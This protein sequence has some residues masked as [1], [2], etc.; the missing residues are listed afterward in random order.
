MAE[1]LYG[2]KNTNVS[3][4]LTKNI[5]TTYVPVSASIFLEDK[6]LRLPVLSVGSGELKIEER[7]F[8][9]LIGTKK[10]KLKEIV[11][12]SECRNPSYSKSRRAPGVDMGA[13]LGDKFLLEFEIKLTVVPTHA[14]SKVTEMIVRQNTQFNFAE[15]L[16]YKFGRYLSKNPS[17]S[18]L[19]SI[20]TKQE[21]NQDLFILHGIWKTVNHDSRIDQKN[22]LDVVAITDLAYLKILLNSTH[23]KTS[24]GTMIKTRIGRVVD[25]ILSWIK[26]FKNSD[27]I[28]YLGDSEG[29]RDHLKITLYPFEHKPELGKIY[30]AP[31]LNFSELQKIVLPD[32]IKQLSPERRLDASIIF[33]LANMELDES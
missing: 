29:S 10:D 20:L 16:C 23:E 1:E 11:W 8:S 3:T 31:R 9:E 12:G 14:E 33:T 2:V 24:R 4:V 18:E 21:K 26:E 30:S 28:T 5:F 6:N 13:S 27:K 22:S 19:K 25:Q 17:I 32:S 15:R 7:F